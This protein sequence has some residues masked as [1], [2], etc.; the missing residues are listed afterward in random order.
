MK[1]WT[2][3]KFEGHYPVGVSAVVVANTKELAAFILNQKL[4]AHGLKQTAKADDMEWLPTDHEQAV[5]LNNG[6]Y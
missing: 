5:V 1:V 3:T 4:L 6:D 2:N